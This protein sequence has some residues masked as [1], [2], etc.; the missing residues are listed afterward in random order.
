MSSMPW[1][2][3]HTEILDD[4]KLGRLG[5]GDKWRFVAL[6]VL[7]GECDAEGW[8]VDGSEPLTV[9]DIAWRLREDSETLRVSMEALAE[10]GLLTITD[11][12]WIVTNF[13]KWNPRPQSEKRAAWR[14]RKRR[15]RERDT[16]EDDTGSHGETKED[17]TRDTS[18]TPAGVPAPEQEADQ[19]TDKEQE[20]D[21]EQQADRDARRARD[22][23]VAVADFEE[24]VRLLSAFG[25]DNADTLARASPLAHVRGW[26]EIAKAAGERLESPT[27]LVVARLRAGIAPPHKRSAAE[28]EEGWRAFLCKEC[29]EFPCVC[30]GGLNGG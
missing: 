8:L 14:E 5:A 23:P 28:D 27:G 6:C 25:I 26:I 29:G 30:P 17:V 7:A 1:I 18:G 4:P 22:G 21:Q 13:A 10:L 2:K 9:G 15:Q 12:A 19:E 3:I 24:S 16:D 20:A 11:G